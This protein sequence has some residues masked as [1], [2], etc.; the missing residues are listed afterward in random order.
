MKTCGILTRKMGILTYFDIFWPRK[1][2]VWLYKTFL[3]ARNGSKRAWYPTTITDS[4]HFFPGNMCRC[5]CKAW[6]CPKS[7]TWPMQTSVAWT[8]RNRRSRRNAA[9]HWRG[10]DFLDST[11]CTDL[12][13]FS[14]KSSSFV[15][16]TTILHGVSWRTVY[17]PSP[18][19]VF[20]HKCVYV[21]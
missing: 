14:W 18:C 8:S 17:S 4:F 19:S 11:R 2:G 5:R 6:P 7:L 15:M 12:A 9:G 3:N 16:D 13:Q 1:L 21:V 20:A 10:V